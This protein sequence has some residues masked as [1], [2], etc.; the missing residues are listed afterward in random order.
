MDTRLI[1]CAF[2]LA[3]A[4][5]SESKTASEDIVQRKAEDES[6][7]QATFIDVKKLIGATKKTVD[8][9]Y[10]SPECPPKNACVYGENFEVFYVDGLAANLTLPP[11]DDLKSYGMELETPAFENPQTGLVVWDSLINGQKAEIRK[12]KNYVYVKTAEP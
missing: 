12:F 6:V 3:L 1:A 10:G 11:V 7:K 4:G 9:Q 8:A 2:A 5:C